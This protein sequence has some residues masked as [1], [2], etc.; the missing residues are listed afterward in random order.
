MT[1][2]GPHVPTPTLL[3]SGKQLAEQ[4]RRLNA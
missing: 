1:T 2:T 3:C 4:N